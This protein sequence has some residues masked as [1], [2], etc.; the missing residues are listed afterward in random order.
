MILFDV[1]VSDIVSLSSKHKLYSMYCTLPTSYPPWNRITSDA[2]LMFSY[3]F[4]FIK[5]NV[6]P[7]SQV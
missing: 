6:S 2:I 3:K 5:T 1:K 4:C 7:L